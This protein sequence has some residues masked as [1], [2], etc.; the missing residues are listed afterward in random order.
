MPRLEKNSKKLSFTIEMFQLCGLKTEQRRVQLQELFVSKKC[1]CL[2][3]VLTI[4]FKSFDE[5]RKF[6]LISLWKPKIEIWF[7]IATDNFSGGFCRDMIKHSDEQN[8]L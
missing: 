1:G 4:N 6:S 3:E 7:T 5:A 8:L 2:F